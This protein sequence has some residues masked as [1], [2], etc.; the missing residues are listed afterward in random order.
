MSFSCILRTDPCWSLA[1]GVCTAGCWP[2]VLL[3]LLVRA[4]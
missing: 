3:V 1:E 2:V 4:T